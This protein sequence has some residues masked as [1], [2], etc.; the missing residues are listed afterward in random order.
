MILIFFFSFLVVFLY[1]A[2]E[3]ILHE[4]RLGR[5][6]IRIHVNGTRGKSSVTRLIA[7][8]LRQAGI[9]TLA[10]TTGT[11]PRL[12][13]PDGTEETIRRR[14]P[15]R[16]LEQILFIRRAEKLRVEA[17][18]VE[19]MA[20]DPAL[21]FIS[22][23]RMIRSVIG[24]ITNVRP[25]HF[26]TMGDNLDDIARSLS[27]TIPAGGILVTADRRYHPFFEAIAKEKRTAAFL[28][29]SPRSE[30]QHPG[31]ANFLFPEN[32]AIAEK[33]CSL[34]G[35]DAAAFSAGLRE[36]SFVREGA[37]VFRF[38]VGSKQ[39]SFVDAFSANDADSTRI[40]Q[41]RAAGGG[42]CPRPWVALFN[43]RADRPL[44]LR[45][46]AEAFFGDPPFDYLALT[47]EARALARRH[48]RRKTARSRVFSL[49]NSEPE[50][51]LGELLREI[52]GREVTIV[53]MGNEK[54]PG[55]LLSNFLRGAPPR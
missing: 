50:K 55:R 31:P 38:D 19:C 6:P 13:L 42:L 33:V 15:A 45:S 46:F 25:D 54:G 27:Q 11:T 17:V 5:I 24:V 28:V 49:K 26:E 7:S 52:P 21:Q 48:G 10:K 53:G 4:K 14:R 18:V 12:I 39:V 44:R 1:L 36:A 23:T 9:R 35:V 40:I 8:V 34:L 41:E 22:E 16:L 43:N 20:V 51:L 30:F 29:D 3:K 32:I 37:G 2:A 47:G